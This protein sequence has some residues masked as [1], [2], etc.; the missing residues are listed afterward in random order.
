M[1]PDGVGRVG[2]RQRV[3]DLVALPGGA[4]EHR[5]G[6]QPPD[7]QQDGDELRPVGRHDRDPLTCGD[8]AFGQGRGQPVGQRVELRQAELPFL[9]HERGRLG[10]VPSFPRQAVR[11]RT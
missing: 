5:R 4:D 2:Q 8:T 11:H 6:I 9:E 10:H 7:R 1:V 3:V